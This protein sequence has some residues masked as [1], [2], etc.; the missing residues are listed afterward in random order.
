MSNDVRVSDDDVVA[1]GEAIAET[2]AVLDAATHR[3]LTQLRAFDQAEGWQRA[4]ALSCAHWLS[5]RVGMDLG[6]AREKVRVARKLADLPAIDRAMAEGTISYSKVRAMTRVATASNQD[7]LLTMARTATGAQLDRI[8]R[9]ARQVKSFAGQTPRDVEERQRYAVCRRTEDGMASIKIR[10]H[11][12]EAVRVMKALE[13]ASGGG[14][15]ADGVVALAESALAAGGVP[16]PGESAPGRSPVEVV[17]HIAADTLTGQ[18]CL[19]DGLSAE[20]S[21]RLLCDSGVVPLLEDARGKT[22]DVGRKHRT[23]HAALQRALHWRDKGC[24]FPGCTNTRFLDAHHAVHWINGGET[25]L[26]NTLLV[27]RRHHRYLHEYG[28]SVET[29][30]DDFLFLD[31]SGR[32]VP[33]QGERPPLF[34]DPVRHLREWLPE[35]GSM[36]TA[37]SNAPGW[38]GQR[39]DYDL[40]VAAIFS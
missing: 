30:G 21:R 16:A 38:D 40:A 3:F 37:E 29:A 31:P 22:L 7:D 39:V 20:V 9:L 8:G 15:L 4:G 27:C 26:E 25:N 13:V 35:G 34:G 32:V 14:N 5:W 24:R 12:D 33:P 6:A 1:L 2:A 23:I 19:G 10:L 28:Y 17:V 11:P 18:T 36:V